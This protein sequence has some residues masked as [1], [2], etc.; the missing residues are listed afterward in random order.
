MLPT[1]SRIRPNLTL[2]TATAEGIVP[3][4]RRTPTIVTLRAPWADQARPGDWFAA[5]AGRVAFR[6]LEVLRTRIVCARY[7]PAEWPAGV[8]PRPWPDVQPH[9]APPPRSRVSRRDHLQR[10]LRSGVISERQFAAAV[11]FRDTI[12]QA[13]PSLPVS[14]LTGPCGSQV[15]GAV[16][17]HERHL[18]A[19]RSVESALAAIGPDHAS[20]VHSVVINNQSIAR[21]A[22]QVRVRE[23][24][25]ADRL[26]SALSSLD[27]W[28]NPLVTGP[29]GW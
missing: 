18:R 27:A 24:T 7:S 9:Q 28:Y 21:Y 3:R 19:R 29:W 1:T 11:R 14:S 20:A 2:E 8:K 22:A 25:A 5:P 4:V 13:S 16:P 17:V 15:V 23:V 26:C 12:E 6:V 10:L